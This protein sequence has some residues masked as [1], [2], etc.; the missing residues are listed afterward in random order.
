MKKTLLASALIAATLAPL[1][2]QAQDYRHDRDQREARHDDRRDD[3][4]AWRG[5]RRDDRQDARRDWHQDRRN[6]RHEDWQRWRESHRDEYRRG[7]WNAPFR[8]QQFAIGGIVPRAFWSSQYYVSDWARYRLP[9]PEYGFQR[10]VRHY[11]D[12]LLIN[13]RNGRV[14]RVYRNFYW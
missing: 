6:D 12:L 9:R 4:R 14:L 3:R 1:G 7:R 10:Y 13:T 5:D 8:Y 2:A 11:D